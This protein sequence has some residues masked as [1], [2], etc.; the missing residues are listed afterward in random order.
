VG[1]VGLEGKDTLPPA[2]VD[3]F[4]NAS[5]PTGFGAHCLPGHCYYY[6]VSLDG[7]GVETWSTPEQIRAFLGAIGAPEEALLIALSREYSWSG[8]EK[9]IGA[10][11]PA[12]GGVEL[13]VTR[14]VSYC[15][16][17]QVNRFHVLVGPTGGLEVLREEVWDRADGVCI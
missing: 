12:E 8:T 16:P 17:V 1:G 11:R 4:E 2:V 13:V 5:V 6:V 7:Q 14:I 9:A 15:D 3:A 10:F